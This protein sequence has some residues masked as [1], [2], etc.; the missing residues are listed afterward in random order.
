MATVFPNNV[1]LAPILGSAASPGPYFGWTISADKQSSTGP[2][3][4]AG[5]GTPNGVT[6]APL[7]SLWIQSDSAG[8]FRNTNGATAWSAV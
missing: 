4:Y 6:T 7:G 1:I 3:I 8:F 2:R 5:S